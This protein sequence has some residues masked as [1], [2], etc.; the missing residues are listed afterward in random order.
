V[1]LNGYKGFLFVSLG[2]VGWREVGWRPSRARRRAQS[3]C[4]LPI[5]Q[6]TFHEFGLFRM[7]GPPRLTTSSSEPK[8]GGK[9]GGME[10]TFTFG[11]GGSRTT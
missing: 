2:D 10:I 3:L 7:G 11:C 5:G 4:S 6:A 8:D 1:T 9:D